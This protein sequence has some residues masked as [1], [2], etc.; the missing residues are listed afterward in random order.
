MLLEFKNTMRLI[1]EHG[2][3]V[4]MSARSFGRRL[5]LTEEAQLELY[6]AGRWHDYGK[7]MIPLEI[8]NKPA[9]LSVEEFEV[10]KKHPLYS[11][12]LL[13]EMDCGVN[14]S[15]IIL[16]HHESYN[17]L[18][19]PIGLAKDKIP[20]GAQ[21]LTLSDVYDAL[22]EQRLYKEPLSDSETM[23]IM[24]E[25]NEKG[26]FN[27]YLFKEFKKF[28]KEIDK[29]VEEYIGIFSRNRPDSGSGI[30]VLDESRRWRKSS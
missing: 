11:N 16:Y 5:G 25:D 17:G 23:K 28:H 18:G 3:R 24:E 8:L 10:I 22:A 26:K 2:K 12:V 29:D 20:F 30:L 6:V 15:E 19:Y 7:L 27:K 13:T 4:G 9:K 21:V 14:I 1:H